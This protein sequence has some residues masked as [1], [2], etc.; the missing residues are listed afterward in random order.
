MYRYYAQKRSPY[1]AFVLDSAVPYADYTGLGHTGNIDTGSTTPAKSASLV[2]GAAYS[3]VYKAGCIG[4]FQCPLFTQGNETRQ[5]ALEAWAYPIFVGGTPTGAQSILSHKNTL[6]GLT[7]NGTVLSF[8]TAYLTAASATCSYDLLFARAV[9]AVGVHTVDQ[10]Q[11]WVNGVQ[12]ASVDLTD[13]QKA[14]SYV[15]TDGFLYSGYTTSTQC[16]AMNGVAFYPN[17]TGDMAMQNY[18]AG[19]DVLGQDATAKQF[20]G[21]TLNLRAEQGNDFIERTW[22]TFDD[23]QMGYKNNVEYG[24]EAIVP[25]YMSGLSVAGTWTVGMP[26]DAMGDTS[27]Y[28]VMLEWSGVAVTVAWSL[29][30]TVWNTATNGALISGITSGY[31]PTAKD[32]QVRVSM[33][34]GVAT[35]PAFFES[36]H[37]IGFRDNTFDNQTGRAVTVAYPAVIRGDFEPIMY[38]EDNGVNLHST[39]LTIGTDTTSDPHVA[40]SVEIWIKPISGT[41]TFSFSGTQ[42]RNGA[43]DST[44]PI[45]Q[46]SLVHVVAAANITTTMTITGDCI[47]GQVS[48]YPTALSAGT[49]LAIYQS[50][51]GT[52]RF[53]ISDTNVIGVTESAPPTQIYAHDWSIDAAG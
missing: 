4:K 32:L 28:G 7:I 29:N 43:V 6:D 1:S 46:W 18:A 5:F 52:P 26:L 31:N 10:N 9:Y 16:V 37:V 45:G 39:A 2:S 23:F 25:R 3:S 19:I 51:T 35:D 38:R 44:L 14:D 20:D 17:F 42:Y 48:Y 27:I 13:A 22:A 34:T 30:G 49:V 24:P 53:R 15:A 50:Y 11:L 36:L 41:P 40:R 47:V 21:I 8:T 12:V 33:G